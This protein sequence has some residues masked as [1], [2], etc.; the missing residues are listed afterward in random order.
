MSN[1]TRYIPL[2]VSVSLSTGC[3]QLSGPA[4]PAHTPVP[5]NTRDYETLEEFVLRVVRSMELVRYVD[6]DHRDLAAEYFLTEKTTPANPS[7]A[8]SMGKDGPVPLTFDWTFAEK[9][10]NL[11]AS[12]G[13]L[14]E[15]VMIMLF[16]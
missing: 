11:E 16:G 10:F 12:S 3:D 6:R 2:L 5:A 8:P 15:P 1:L 7:E 9:N 14:P 4:A 13:M